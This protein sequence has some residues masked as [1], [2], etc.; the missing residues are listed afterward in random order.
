MTK[1]TPFAFG[2]HDEWLAYVR[3]EIPVAKQ[4]YAL[5]FGRT[6]LFRSFYRMQRLPFPTEFAEELKRIETLHDPEQ[7][8]AL[9]LLNDMIFRSLTQ[10]SVQP[11]TAERPQG[12]VCGRHLLRRKSWGICS[13]ILRR[14]QPLLR[15]LDRLQERRV[16]QFCRRGLGRLSPSRTRRRERGGD[17]IRASYGRVGQ[18]PE[19][20]S[21]RKSGSSQP[22]I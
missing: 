8:A 4:S 17:R 14:R 18:A 16:R 3:S 1:T 11:G 20:L 15:A 19:C 5:A 21:R 22:C 13:P 2:S 7:T 6:E 9:E 10:A 12:A